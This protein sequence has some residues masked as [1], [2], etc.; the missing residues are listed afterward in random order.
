MKQVIIRIVKEGEPKR[1]TLTYVNRLP[2]N[3]WET[4]IKPFLT[5]QK[6]F[7][8]ATKT[9]TINVIIAGEKNHA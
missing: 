4:V 5:G 9:L 1:A 6:K 2:N 3:I 8:K 7:G